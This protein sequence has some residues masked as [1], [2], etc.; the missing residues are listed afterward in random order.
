MRTLLSGVFFAIAA[1][2]TFTASASDKIFL[3]TGIRE[4]FT[5]RDHKGF[6]D[7]VVKEAFKRAGLNAEVVVYQ[8]SANSLSNANE[9]IDDGVA[10]RIKGLEKKFPNLIRIPEKIMDNDF[11]AYSLTPLSLE[12]VFSSLK[13]YKV[14]HVKGWQIFIKNLQDHPNVTVVKN[15]QSMFDK[16]SNNSVDIMLYE[17]W[18]GLWR[19]KQSNIKLQVS[20]PPLAKMEMFMYLHKKHKSHVDDVASAL[21]SMKKDGTYQKIFTNTLGRLKE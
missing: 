3:N 2:S 11:V 1:L 16:L 8:N 4:P 17:R 13:S 7:L 21:A 19:A 15:P 5:T 12:N 9:G 14:T 18:Q 20:E 6:I 10:L